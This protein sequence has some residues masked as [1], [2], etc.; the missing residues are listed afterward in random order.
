MSDYEKEFCFA[1]HQPLAEVAEKVFPAM[2]R[3][4]GVLKARGVAFSDQTMVFS[5]VTD[6]LYVDPWCHFNQQGNDL[7]AEQIFRDFRRL[8]SAETTH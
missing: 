2:V 6:T 1:E 4:G 5:E 3:E 7:L 8:V